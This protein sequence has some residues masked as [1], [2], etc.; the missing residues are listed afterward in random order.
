MC[1]MGMT[2]I[3]V[4]EEVRLLSVLREVTELFNAFSKS[5]T[6]ALQYHFMKIM[7]FLVFPYL[8]NHISHKVLKDSS[9]HSRRRV[10]FMHT[11]R[12]QIV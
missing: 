12:I 9:K 10:I 7:Y 3:T 8:Y 5:R 4:R 2:K 1:L 6:S 11:A